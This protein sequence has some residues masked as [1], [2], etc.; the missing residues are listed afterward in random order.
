MAFVA[1]PMTVSD[2]ARVVEVHHAAFAPEFREG[3]E[4]IRAM[5]AVYPPGLQDEQCAGLASHPLLGSGCYVLLQGKSIEGYL[6]AHPSRVA[7]IPPAL[8]VSTEHD[9]GHGSDGSSDPVFYVHAVAVHPSIQGS[10]AGIRILS[11][12]TMPDR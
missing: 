12:G 1:R 2:L 3:L 9:G 5:Q 6:F 4:T 10:G 7:L 11:L 8:D